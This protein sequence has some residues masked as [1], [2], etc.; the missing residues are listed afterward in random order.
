MHTAGRSGSK[1]EGKGGWGIKCRGR[2][3]VSSADGKM[4]VL[5]RRSQ[6]ACLS[7]PTCSPS[8]RRRATQARLLPRVT[9]IY[10][11]THNSEATCDLFLHPSRIPCEFHSFLFN[12]SRKV[13][14]ATPNSNVAF[15][16]LGWLKH[17]AH[18]LGDNLRYVSRSAVRLRDRSPSSSTGIGKHA[19]N[20]VS[21]QTT[22]SLFLR[23][24]CSFSLDSCCT[25][26]T[27]HQ[28]EPTWV[29]I[30]TYL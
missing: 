2:I 24:I 22:A 19:Q 7:A 5:Q 13:P 14:P 3:M 10:I 28:D 12:R 30:W 29:V 4:E 16:R 18:T 27:A 15:V 9:N 6:P 26:F 1:T 23:S 25:A 8:P 21:C 11:T 20:S 17:A